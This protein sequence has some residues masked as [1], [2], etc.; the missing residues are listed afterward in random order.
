MKR[1]GTSIKV[2]GRKTEE[3]GGQE[4]NGQSGFGDDVTRAAVPV[5][6][7][8]VVPVC[9][10]RQLYLQLAAVFLYLVCLAWKTCSLGVRATPRSELPSRSGPTI[11]NSADKKKGFQWVDNPPVFITKTFKNGLRDEKC[12]SS[13]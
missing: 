10:H 4:G 12:Q 8:A 3:G 13:L 2:E 7:D 11:W 1:I 9:H 6:L 5:A